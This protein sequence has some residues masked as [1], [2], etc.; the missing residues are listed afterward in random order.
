[1]EV[2]ALPGFRF[3]RE[4]SGSTTMREPVHCHGEAPIVSLNESDLAFVSDF[5]SSG[6]F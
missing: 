2:V 3:W 5:K 6:T 4:I 1:M